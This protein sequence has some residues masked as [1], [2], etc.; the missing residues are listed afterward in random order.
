MWGILV[1]SSKN[2][3]NC[4]LCL[5]FSMNA[6]FGIDSNYSNGKFQMKFN[7]DHWMLGNG[8]C[9][10][11]TLLRQKR[12]RVCFD[13]EKWAKDK[14]EAKNANQSEIKR[15]ACLLTLRE[16]V[17]RTYA[18]KT[19]SSE[20]EACTRH[21]ENSR[22]NKISYFSALEWLRRWFALP[23]NTTA[24]PFKNPFANVHWIRGNGRRITLSERSR[25]GH[26][27]RLTIVISKSQNKPRIPTKHW[28]IVFVCRSILSAVN[29]V[30]KERTV[31]T[32]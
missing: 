8:Q 21:M 27:L 22:V 4:L 13:S 14:K 20:K 30:I 16:A 11:H 19:E 29:N 12:Y 25:V 6:S 26:V 1:F 17:K 18:K 32:I 9:A 3:Q 31:E 2:T 15:K 24:I 7:R 23:I 28:R 5:A 10:R